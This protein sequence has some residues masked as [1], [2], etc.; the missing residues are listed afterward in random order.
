MP[1]LPSTSHSSSTLNLHPPTSPSG[2]T[3]PS[4]T[5]PTTPSADFPASSAYQA[6]LAN[7]LIAASHAEASKGVHSDLLQILNHSG[8]Q[9]GF[10]YSTYPHAVR[11]WYGDRDEKI[12]ENAVRWMERTMGPDTC[13][14]KVVKG[15][16]HALMYNSAVVIEAM[17]HVRD[18]WK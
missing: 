15:A 9:W 7:A 5:T 14:V 13:R 2:F 3:T 10:S 16:D 8:R 17:E 4:P 12:A 11:V 1:S 6:S 18:A